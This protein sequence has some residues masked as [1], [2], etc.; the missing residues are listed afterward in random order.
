[1][2]T[3]N[4]IIQNLLGYLQTITTMGDNVYFQNALNL[5]DQAKLTTLWVG[6]LCNTD[7]G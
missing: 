4:C 3:I 1:M 5:A 2:L 7:V 6:G